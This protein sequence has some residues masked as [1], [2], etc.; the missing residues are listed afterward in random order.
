MKK[1]GCYGLEL[2]AKDKYK[3]IFFYRFKSVN[4]LQT[5]PTVVVIDIIA[6]PRGIQSNLS[7]LSMEGCQGLKLVAKN[8]YTRISVSKKKKKKKKKM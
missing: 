5:L 6:F 2:I 8:K 7:N 3:S 1:D 4:C